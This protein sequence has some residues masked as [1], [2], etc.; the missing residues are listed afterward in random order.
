MT[1]SVT[2]LGGVRTVTGSKF[3]IETA[4]SR[5]V[6][7]CGLFQGLRD[8][9]A[10]NWEP[11]PI[12]PASIDAVVLTHAH[13][14]HTGAVP[15]LVRDG[16]RGRVHATA[17][18]VAL[19]AILL[20]DSGHLQ[21]EDAEHANHRGS[22][23]HHPA[24]PLYTEEDALRS[25]DSLQPAEFGVP[26][27]VAEDVSVAFHVAGHILGSATVEVRTPSATLHFSGDLG[28]PAHHPLLTAPAPLPAADVLLLEST[29]GD[30]IHE[31]H[32]ATVAQLGDAITRTVRRGGSVVIPAF[33][34]DRTEVV[35]AALNTLRAS[36]A[37]PE[38]PVH[39]DSPM[40]LRALRV[41]RDALVR[42]AVDI[43]PDA[44]ADPFAA[45]DLREA[46]RP[47]DSMA[48]NDL[49][50]PSI[51]VSASGMAS[52]GRVLHHL[53]RRL[54][55]HRSTIVLAGFQAAGTR[56][57]M[58]ADGARAVKLYGRYVPVHAEVVALAG[59]SSHAD[60]DELL[61]WC[62][63][64]PTP[65]GAVFVVHGE[66]SASASLAADLSA[67]FDVLAVVPRM[68]ERVLA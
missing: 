59:L 14:D 44:A 31:Q 48:L 25:L 53:E 30:R 51:I 52:G 40:A 5:V 10:R 27:D 33:A 60:R 45:L 24:L 42:R 56:G 61:A 46:P 39:V 26:V 49:A 13:L 36:G 38:L 66:E 15:L 21:E 23:K 22:S 6:V 17:D 4:R 2:F 58:L 37:I 12:A 65:P 35:L 64:A 62:A 50:Y 1:S 3:L 55:D 32:D 18:T 16:Y 7:D 11:F 19:A 29:Y 20:P 8:L 34:V 9:R 54:P 57:R 63:T 67:R 41:Y 47:E 28:R 43:R 68:G